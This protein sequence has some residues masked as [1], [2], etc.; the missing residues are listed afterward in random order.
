MINNKALAFL[1]GVL[2][3]IVY[4]CSMKTKFKKAL[5][6]ALINTCSA[7]DYNVEGDTVMAYTI[8]AERAIFNALDK[9]GL[10][11]ERKI[12]SKIPYVFTFYNIERKTYKD[13]LI[14][15]IKKY[16]ANV[17]YKFKTCINLNG[18]NMIGV[19]PF[20]N[21]CIEELSNTNSCLPLEY[22]KLDI[23]IGILEKLDTYAYTT[24][25]NDYN[26][27]FNLI[28]NM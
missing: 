24:D 19:I 3:L 21:I 5:K 8:K 16:D 18:S 6:D 9:L 23:L 2:K 17:F 11:Y 22:V 12:T 27:I 26:K 1:L 7:D 25:D 13:I 14:E 10:I 4:L 15:S 28:C 20:K